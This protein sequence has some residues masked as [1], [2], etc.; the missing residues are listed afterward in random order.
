MD[1]YFRND[2]TKKEIREIRKRLSEVRPLENMRGPLPW[3]DEQEPPQVREDPPVRHFA[4]ARRQLQELAREVD[5][6]LAQFETI[7]STDP[8]DGVASVA[9]CDKCPLVR[10]DPD[11]DDD[12]WIALC[13]HPALSGSDRGDCGEYFV[14]GTVP[15]WC[16][17]RRSPLLVHLDPKVLPKRSRKK[18]A[19]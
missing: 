15:R 19:G 2:L 13:E 8:K 3:E 9:S 6:R 7:L 11:E 4:K 5:Q 14:N 17:L 10:F 18:Q 16:P 1:M 12:T